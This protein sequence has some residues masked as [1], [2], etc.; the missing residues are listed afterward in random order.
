MD[1]A[2]VAGGQVIVM[3]LLM[4]VGFGLYKLR[5]LKED[6]CAQLNRFLVVLITP[7]IM[8]DSF[9]REFEMQLFKNLCVGFVMFSIAMAVAVLVSY[10]F[11]RGKGEREKIDRFAASFPNCGFMGLP[12]ISAVL[13]AEGVVYATAAMAVFN[14]SQWLFGRTMLVGRG[15]AKTMLRQILLSPGVIGFFAALAV[16]LIPF[17]LPS[18]LTSTISY[19]S[20]MYTPTAMVLVGAYIAR[21]RIMELIGDWRVYRVAAL[22]L[23]LVP[24]LMLPIYYF[25]KADPTVLMA[26]Y[27]AT[28]C[29]VA[30]IA[31]LFPPIFGMDEKRGSGLIAVTTVLSILTIPLMVLLKSTVGA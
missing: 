20:A 4:G 11:I 14:I 30:A 3:F 28:C 27:L 13:G 6:G 12:L 9:N 15:D 17:S 7:M 25:S 8:V 26:S 10:I 5:I 23:V 16:L 1:T 29:P 31:S 22:R 19:I 21:T 18:P 2:I 24:A